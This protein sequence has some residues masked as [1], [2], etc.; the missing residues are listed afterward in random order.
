MFFDSTQSLQDISHYVGSR[1]ATTHL[2][3]GV[4]RMILNSSDGK[5]SRAVVDAVLL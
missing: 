4:T 2:L 1:S 3:S 5:V